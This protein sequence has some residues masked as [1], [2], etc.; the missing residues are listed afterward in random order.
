MRTRKTANA[1][2]GAG[3]S[4]ALIRTICRRLAENKG[5]RRTLS[6]RGRLHV[7]RQLPF[8]CVYRR[9]PGDVGTARLVTSEAAYLVTPESEEGR[10]GVS[11]L[12][13][14]LV[15]TMAAEFGAYLM[16][17][18]WAAPDGGKSNDPAVPS[19]SPSFEIIAPKTVALSET[20]DVLAQGL[21]R[22]KILK[23]N[24]DVEITR[25]ANPWPPGTTSLLEPEVARE[26]NCASIGLVVPPV[27][28]NVR[29]GQEFPLI[30]R[31]FRRA[32][33]QAL[34]P[35]FYQFSRSRTT[36]RPPH[37]HEL[38]RRAV[39]KAVWK[40]DKE[41][42]DV[43][44]AFDF[45]LQATP[46]N[47]E[48]A[49]EEFKESGYERIPEFHYR[50]MPY[51]PALLKRKLYK[52]SIDR[53]EDPALQHIFQEKQEELEYKITML[54]DRDTSKFLYGSLQ[55]YGGIEDEL[56]QLAQDIL[57]RVT[58]SRGGKPAA[59]RLDATAFAGRALAEFEYYR[60][61]NPAFT[62]KT[63]IT[64][65][66]A[67]IM[68]SRGTL[69]INS[70][71][72]VARSRVEALLQHEVGT[73]LLTY[74][75]GRS[76]PFRQLHSGLAGYEELQE[77]LAVLGEYLVGGLGPERI[78]QLAA[79]VVAVRHLLDGASFVE[80]FRVLAH[81]HDFPRRTAFTTTVRVYRGGGLT[82][83]AVY[84]RGLCQI[85]EYLNAGGKLDPVFIGKISVKHIPIIEEL[86]LRG[87]LGPTP[88]RP[89]YASNPDA[90]A[91]LEKL[92]ER[93]ATVLSLLDSATQTET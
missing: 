61:T 12:I 77:G 82:K 50:P 13:R 2:G 65:K 80:T 22:I 21:S 79:R 90:M 78:R 27:Y 85:L 38:G 64:R 5:V 15:G 63:R 42:G 88:F 93:P 36:H 9:L 45:L 89:R 51:D 47:F 53:I 86:R 71:L 72:T 68:V 87:V 70:H 29:T 69:L 56:L 73:H 23:Q 41:L 48:D 18:I 28:R 30:L 83:D 92:R 40:V 19:V 33:G 6:D 3:V 25:G 11:D 39:V 44:S 20:I 74:Y 1:E 46:V 14:E 35:A 57:G 75:N 4:D 16:L 55:L 7:D 8:L 81:T 37:Y 67:G 49:W 52:I 76:Q 59:G 10:A 62:A 91:R 60:R 17:E 31:N 54:R 43:S 84:L 66:V 34:K 26:L 32:L 24:V 58:A